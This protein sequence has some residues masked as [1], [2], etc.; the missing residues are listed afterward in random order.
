M[1]R[2]RSSAAC[3]V[4]CGLVLGCASKPVPLVN[5]TGGGEQWVWP[6][7]LDGKEIA[8]PEKAVAAP[9]EILTL[10]REHNGSKMLMLL[11][12]SPDRSVQATVAAN[13]LGA[14]KTPTDYDTGKPLPAGGVIEIPPLAVRIIHSGTFR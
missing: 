5:V 6:F 2:P 1:L 10:M 11:N 7:F 12:F 9:P 4:L 14:G 3:L 13:C 8:V